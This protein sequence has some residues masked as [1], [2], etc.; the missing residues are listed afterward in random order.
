MGR[1]QIRI[2]VSDVPG[3]DVAKRAEGATGEDTVTAVPLCPTPSSESRHYV[4]QAQSSGSSRSESETRVS[5][6]EVV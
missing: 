6:A 4:P 2:S 5:T 1:A 3:R